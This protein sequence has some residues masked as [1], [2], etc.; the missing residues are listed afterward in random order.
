MNRLAPI[1][2]HGDIGD[3]AEQAQEFANALALAN[4]RAVAVEILESQDIDEDGVVWCLDCAAPVEPERL[5]RHPHLV[6][7]IGCQ[8]AFEQRQRRMAGGH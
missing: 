8:E 3:R 4:H 6:R 5:A 2:Q 1:D 7:C